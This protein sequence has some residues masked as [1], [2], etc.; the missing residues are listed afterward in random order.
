LNV[1]EDIE[2][3]TGKQIMLHGTWWIENKKQYNANFSETQIFSCWITFSGIIIE[4]MTSLWGMPKS[5]I[6]VFYKLAFST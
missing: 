2:V 5:V 6:A 1:C 4:K 3:V